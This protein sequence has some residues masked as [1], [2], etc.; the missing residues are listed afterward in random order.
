M[1]VI[2][3]SQLAFQKLKQHEQN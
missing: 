3:V 2:F 1:I